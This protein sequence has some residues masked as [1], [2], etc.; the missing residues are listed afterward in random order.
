MSVRVGIIDSGVYADHPLV[1]PIAGGVA[2][3]GEDV[4][5]RLGHGT[6]VAATIHAEAPDAELYIVK[7]FDRSLAC[8]IATL[9]RGL[10][11]CIDAQLD[12]I[13]L[14]L[15]TSNHEHAEAL[16]AVVERATAAGIRIVAP[17]GSLPGDIGGVISVEG[18]AAAGSLQGQSFAVAHHTGRL[19]RAS[20]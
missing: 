11:W 1:G 2:I 7:I 20:A 10:E 19:A 6:A 9:L 17:A 16:T 4:T 15:G 5:D 13:N 18:A 3:A 14:S 12:L 8:P